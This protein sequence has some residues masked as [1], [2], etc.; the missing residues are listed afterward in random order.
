MEDVEIEGGEQV[1]GLEER[2]A[3]P[4]KEVPVQD[5]RVLGLLQTDGGRRLLQVEQLGP[6][7]KEYTY[8]LGEA[9]DPGSAVDTI[10]FVNNNTGRRVEYR[11]LSL[12]DTA[13]R[14]GAVPKNQVQRPQDAV[15]SIDGVRVQRESNVIEDALKGVTIE[16]QGESDR[17]VAL[18]VDYDYEKITGGIVSLIEKYNE[19][20]RYINEHTNVVPGTRPEER[21]EAGVLTGETAVMGLKNKLQRIM[22]DPYHT[23][24]GKELS[25]LAQIGISMGPLR[26]DPA[27]IRGGYLT[28]DEDT[29]VPAF[30]RSPEAIKQLFG[31]DTDK[32]AVIDS[33]VAYRLEQTLKG[34]TEPRTGVIAYRVKSMEGRIN[35]Q[36]RKI[37]TFN[38]HLDEYRLK[39]EKDFTLMQ[40]SLH[41]LEQTQQRIENFS[42][43]FKT[44]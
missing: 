34:Y 2:E 23:D 27:E 35:D 31:S 14:A 41:E 28:V 22:M 9:A 30:E 17:E 39:L 18:S 5:D 33:G 12:V 21:A 32:D 42:S 6:E 40:Q 20:L 4:E 7:L 25:L 38:D 16:V 11:D 15:V 10:L 3:E 24:R 19:V 13:E 26:S 43:Q 29:F 8:R 37:A 44:Q 1:S 36:E